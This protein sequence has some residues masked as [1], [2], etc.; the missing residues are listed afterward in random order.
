MRLLDFIVTSTLLYL[1]YRA[2][3]RIVITPAMNRRDQIEDYTAR[4]LTGMLH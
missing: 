3:K 4:A 2:A 1:S